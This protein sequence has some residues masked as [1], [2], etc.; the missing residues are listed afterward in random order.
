M[1]VEVNEA[2]VTEPVLAWQS[3]RVIWIFQ[4]D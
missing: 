4:A 2:F 3:D 1:P